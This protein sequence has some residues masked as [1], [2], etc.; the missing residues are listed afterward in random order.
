MTSTRIRAV[1]RYYPQ[2]YLACHVDHVRTKSNRHHLSSHDSSVLAHLDEAKPTSA[3]ALAKH[4]GVAAST[5]SATLSRLEQLGHLQRRARRGDRR[6]VEIL[7]TATGARAM[8]EASVLD[9]RRLA[10]ML[11][12]LSDA[13]C[14]RAVAGLGLLARAALAYQQK[15]PRRSRW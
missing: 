13:Q 7:L 1:Q 3:G 9:R 12:E 15:A 5:L 11:N 6:Q 10:G 4:L 2:I 8:A 14:R